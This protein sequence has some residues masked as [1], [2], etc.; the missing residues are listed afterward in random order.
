MNSPLVL[1]A[2]LALVACRVSSAAGMGEARAEEERASDASIGG[3]ALVELFTSEGCSSC[4]PADAVLEELARERP[5][6]FALEFHVDY[7]DDLGWADPFASPE[8]T[9]RQR[10]Y[11]RAIGAGGLF[12]PQMIVGG[13]DSFT[14]SDRARAEQ[15]LARALSGPIAVPLSVNAREIGADSVSVDYRAP[16]APSNAVLGIAVV[17]RSASTEV[18]A[19]ENA[20]KRLRHSNVVRSLVVLHLREIAGS[21]LVPIPPTLRRADAEVIAFVQLTGPERMPVLGVA[22]SSLRR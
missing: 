9:E 5:S 7:W 6:V 19:G 11:A 22:R 2:A 15:S 16:S 17:E 20:G 10:H 4:P 1:F 13:T 8:F 12:T 18:R 21:T 14:G 3:A